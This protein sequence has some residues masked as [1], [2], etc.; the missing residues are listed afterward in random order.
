VSISATAS[1]KPNPNLGRLIESIVRPA[2]TV[3]VQSGCE[4]IQ[5][6]AKGFCPVDTGAL[7]D[8]I[9]IT[10][11][12]LD[13]SVRGVISPTMFYA[14]FVEFGTGA[15][16]AGSEG[17]GE[18]PYTLSHPGMPAQPY[19]RPALDESR[20]PILEQFRSTLTEALVNA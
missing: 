14:P 19:M 16:G 4:M 5:T 18:G 8:S 9:G 15:A 1:F 10:V 11:E 20:D 7:R 6:T 17:A 13:N 3:A 12:Q 2:V